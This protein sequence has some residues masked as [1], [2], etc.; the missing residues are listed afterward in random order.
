ML[1]AGGHSYIRDYSSPLLWREVRTRLEVWRL[2]GVGR[3]VLG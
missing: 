3:G 2:V 1:R